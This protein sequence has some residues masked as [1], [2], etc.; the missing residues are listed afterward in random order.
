MGNCGSTHRRKQIYSENRTIL[1]V[2]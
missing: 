1:E 2:D